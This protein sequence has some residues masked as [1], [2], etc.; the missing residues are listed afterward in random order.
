MRA[1]KKLR[2][3]TNERRSYNV[4]NVI[5]LRDIDAVF[6]DIGSPSKMDLLSP[7]PKGN[8]SPAQK[9]DALSSPTPSRSEDLNVSG[10]E[11]IPLEGTEESEMVDKEIP[12]KGHVPLKTSS[13][14]VAFKDLH[15]C[16]DNER[17]H[18][19]PLL[20]GLDDEDP[21]KGDTNKPPSGPEESPL[22]S[23]DEFLESPPK[24]LQLNGHDE[25]T[26]AQS[27]QT[28]KDI[29]ENVESGPL[30]K[31]LCG[32]RESEARPSH[33][34]QEISF[35]TK[36]KETLQPKTA[37]FRKP[38]PSTRAPSPVEVE[39]D[40]L[41]L[42]DEA[43]LLFSIPRKT[44]SRDKPCPQGKSG[45]SQKQAASK[46]PEPKP[47]QTGRG[48]QKQKGT[49]NTHIASQT[50][51]ATGYTQNVSQSSHLAEKSQDPAVNRR[52]DEVPSQDLEDQE[53]PYLHDKQKNKKT[54]AR[55]KCD[56]PTNKAKK[57][58]LDM[59]KKS[60][61]AAVTDSEPHEAQ[62]KSKPKFSDR[63]KKIPQNPKGAAS[64]LKSKEKKAD[65]GR[66][67]Q[68]SK[69]RV[70][71]KAEQSEEPTYESC[72]QQNE[73]SLPDENVLN[74]SQETRQGP[75]NPNSPK[76]SEVPGDYDPDSSGS[77]L[78]KRKRNKPGAWWAINIDPF[79]EDSPPPRPVSTK[80]KIVKEKKKKKE[81]KSDSG[82]NF[83]DGPRKQKA[84]S[85]QN[86][87]AKTIKTD[88]GHGTKK[89][90]TAAGK[91]QQKLAATEP[92]VTQSLQEE[93][94]NG[95]SEEQE[96]LIPMDLSSDRHTQGEMGSKIFDKVYVSAKKHQQCHTSGP[97][98]PTQ[99]PVPEKRKRKG[100]SNKHDS[101][102]P[103]DNKPSPRCSSQERIK[104][105][106]PKACKKKNSSLKSRQDFRKNINVPRRLRDSL[107]T[108][109]AILNSGKPSS[110]AAKMRTA[111]KDSA[112]KNLLNSLDD[113]SDQS[114]EPTDVL[115][116][117]RGFEQDDVPCEIQNSS[118][119]FLE[120]QG[121]LPRRVS[122]RNVRPSAC[123]QKMPNRRI[124]DIE[125]ASLR[126]G[127]SS[128]I[129]LE[130]YEDS[131]D[132]TLP[133]SRDI[134]VTLSEGDICGPPLRPITLLPE[135]WQNLIKWLRHLWPAP[136]KHAGQ[137]ITPDHFHWY[138]YEGRAMGH[139][140][141][142]VC[143]TFANGKLLLGSYMKKPLQVDDNTTCVFN[144][145]TSCVRVEVDGLKLNYNSGQTFMVPQG[146]A[147]SIHNLTQQPAVL[148]YHRMLS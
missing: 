105:S 123:T 69:H 38:A 114:S 96:Q 100:L 88:N 118:S 131:E 99:S 121:T 80:Q 127:P 67:T 92:P 87:K 109:G 60:D 90:K 130:P 84:K 120:P 1:Q 16:E 19:S 64:T 32:S 146:Q 113:P 141:D 40:F 108:F 53:P 93:E 59:R 37:G 112:R 133:S 70:S 140:V 137:V 86:S 18:V 95:P 11:E 17:L 75:D 122:K 15:P 43:P 27:M 126:S 2:Y 106:M 6:D 31:D 107:A 4:N 28:G 74:G 58:S 30:E 66:S 47:T 115:G 71:K 81:K 76:N 139:K 89:S 91:D 12:F 138:T 20:L 77:V 72:G 57:A 48:R 55:G 119:V 104:S 124:S 116:G 147:Y 103:W 34:M 73:Q 82:A 35:Q 61:T 144:V 49:G 42:E 54:H 14:I 26:D 56:K 129:E 98:S 110:I 3:F 63:V 85:K 128:M 7:L 125:A 36:L 102:P 45:D 111:A 135:D 44:D 78:G 65:L 50:N 117:G 148:W 9:E 21:I 142:L 145:C 5:S 51:S 97:E 23:N 41:I 94:E 39:D 22:L 24:K 25:R 8:A 136:A 132:I 101:Q 29:V 79:T 62:A 33:D 83:T 13:P 46:E 52:K 10:C 68:L 143:S 134:P